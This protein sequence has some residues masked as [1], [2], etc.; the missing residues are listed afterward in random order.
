MIINHVM[1]NSVESNIFNSILGYFKRYADSD[2]EIVKS[3]KPIEHA[4]VYHYHRPN[5]E[6]DIRHN[7][8]MT[9]H[10]DLNEHD[11]WLKIDNY[12][13]KYKK[14]KT[15]ICLNSLQKSILQKMGITNTV[16][17]PHGYN[18]DIFTGVNDRSKNFNGKHNLLVTSKRY[19]RRVKGEAYIYEL[20]RYLDP[21]L[22]RFTLVG[23]GRSEDIEYFS[24]FGFEV[25]VHEYLPYRMYP[26]LYSQ[27]SFLFMASHF[28][29]G[30]ANIPEAIVSGVPIICNPIG[31]AKDC[32]TDRYNGIY[33]SMNPIQDADNINNA[34]KN[35]YEIYMTNALQKSTIGRA[36][37]WSQCVAANVEV[38]RSLVK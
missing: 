35:D 5:I 21:T 10:H 4:D 28:E 30:P 24:K 34:C 22:I 37:S 3:V 16:V 31:M 15:I 9:V 12:I 26:K 11:D 8:V 13:F 23:E 19:P 17:I 1:S 33:L 2:I 29:G 36:I 14:A 18:E 25:N 20:L 7:S 6:S 27:A 32:V 38:Y